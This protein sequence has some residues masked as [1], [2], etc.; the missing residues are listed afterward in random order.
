MR[1]QLK[2]SYRVKASL[3][4]QGQEP[5][6]HFDYDKVLQDFIE[7]TAGFYCWFS[8]E[9]AYYDR[10]YVQNVANKSQ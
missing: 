9:K 6:A 2:E 10:Q 4:L 8:C 7:E 1:E 3:F 5:N